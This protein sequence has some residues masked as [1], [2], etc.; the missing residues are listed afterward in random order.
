[1]SCRSYPDC[2]S[3]NDL[4]VARIEAAEVQG[5]HEQARDHRPALE[6]AF[7]ELVADLEAE[8]LAEI[9]LESNFTAGVRILGAALDGLVEP[10]EEPRELEGDQAAGEHLIHRGVALIVGANIRTDEADLVTGAGRD[11]KGRDRGFGRG[12]GGSVEG[13]ELDFLAEG[14]AGVVADAFTGRECLAVG[15]VEIA[16]TLDE[17]SKNGLRGEVQTDVELRLGLLEIR[18]EPELVVADAV[19]G[20]ARALVAVPPVADDRSDRF[21]DR[22]L[23]LDVEDVAGAVPRVLSRNHAVIDHRVGISRKRAVGLELL[24]EEPQSIGLTFPHVEAQASGGVAAESGGV[25]PKAIR[26][27]GLSGGV[28]EIDREVAEDKTAVLVDLGL[29]HILV[30]VDVDTLIAELDVERGRLGDGHRAGGE[31]EDGGDRKTE[32][33]HRLTSYFNNNGEVFE[34]CTVTWQ[35][36]Q[37]WYLGLRRSWNDGGCDP[38]VL[39]SK[40]LWHSRQS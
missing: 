33:F 14:R 20:L 29:E 19:G 38:R 18:G 3:A 23:E 37:F 9:E 6:F 1:M 24:V 31:D 26:K 25:D 35:V 8:F 30:A 15:A 34:P 21:P 32:C 5:V 2:D 36:V 4:D 39:P 10:L 22:E 12:P 17:G 28:D 16:P 7:A 13:V 27:T 11:V 40:T